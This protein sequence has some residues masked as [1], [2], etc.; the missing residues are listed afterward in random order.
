MGSKM[1]PNSELFWDAS[2][3]SA[4][5]NKGLLRRLSETILHVLN[6]QSLDCMCTPMS[7]NDNNRTCRGFN[8]TIDFIYAGGWYTTYI[9]GMRRILSICMTLITKNHL[10][11]RGVC[12]VFY[13]VS[14]C[15]TVQGTSLHWCY[16]IEICIVKEAVFFIVVT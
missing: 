15:C 12:L 14:V 4:Q 11:L 16:P 3:F 9:R 10:V 5:P 2:E 13:N 7:M 8:V 1:T 6:S